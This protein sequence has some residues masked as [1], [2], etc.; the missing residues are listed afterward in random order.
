MPKPTVLTASQFAELDPRESGFAHGFGIFE[1]MK[2]AAGRLYLFDA[3]WHRFMSSAEALGLDCDVSAA[4]VLGGIRELVGTDGLLNAV[5]KLS[6]LREGAQTKLF[7]YSRPSHSCPKSISL[8]LRS[9][10]PINESSPLAGHKTHNYME[11]LLLLLEAKSAGYS[12][13]LR[14]N[15]VGELAETAVGNFYFI[16]D[17][18]LQTPSLRCGVLPGTR[19]ELVLQLAR[20]MQLEVIEGSFG[21]DALSDIDGAFVTNASVGVL[22]VHR[23]SGAGVAY[24]TSELMPAILELSHAL[25]DYETEH[26][27]DV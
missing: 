13:V 22:P 4:E 21:L 12:D 19:R 11:N 6:L 14:V 25:A 5:I 9:D 3:H 17:G 10:A 7:I 18:R 23:L 16:R 1:T 20:D 15:T 26:R 2:L 27:M 8:Q 24:E